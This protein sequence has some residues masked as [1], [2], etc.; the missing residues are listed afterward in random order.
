VLV[1]DCTELDDVVESELDELAAAVVLVV[2]LDAVLLAFVLEAAVCELV[3]VVAPSR[4]ASTPPS[5]SIDATLSAVAAFRARAARGLRR[6]RGVGVG[7]SM[8]MK[9]RTSGERPP[10]TG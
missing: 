1:T 8:T 5:E 2:A 7:S 3:L 4:Q 10:R 9:V 6:G